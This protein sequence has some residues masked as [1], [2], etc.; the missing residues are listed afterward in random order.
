[1]SNVDECWSKRCSIIINLKKEDDGHS[2]LNDDHELVW[3]ANSD[4]VNLQD[5]AAQQT[6]SQGLKKSS[7]SFS[8]TTHKYIKSS[9]MP[10]V[11]THIQHSLSSRMWKKREY[12]NT[13]GPFQH[14]ICTSGS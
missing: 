12:W 7:L 1:M 14:L 3:Q 2:N 5:V 6:H 4:K 11:C 10:S 8:S 9:M 13:F